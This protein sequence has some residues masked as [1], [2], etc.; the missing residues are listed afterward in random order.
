VKGRTDGQLGPGFDETAETRWVTADGIKTY[1]NTQQKNTKHYLSD[2]KHPVPH[3]D[4]EVLG[5]G[6]FF[7]GKSP[8]RANGY[9]GKRRRGKRR[10]KP[11]L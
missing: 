8:G 9:S 5:C 2:V 3:H 1:K 6:G 10:R 11:S 7:G 4:C